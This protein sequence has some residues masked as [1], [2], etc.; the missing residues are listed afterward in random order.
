MKND[1]ILLQKSFEEFQK[2]VEKALKSCEEIKKGNWLPISESSLKQTS[3]VESCIVANEVHEHE[4]V[5]YWILHWAVDRLRRNKEQDFSDPDWRNYASLYFPYFMGETFD[6]L[7]RRIAYEEIY[8]TRKIALAMVAKLLHEELQTPLQQKSRKEYVVKQRYQKRSSAEKQIIALLSVFD[9]PLPKYEFQRCLQEL[10]GADSQTDL[11][12]LLNDGWI[13]TQAEVGRVEIASEL[14]LHLLFQIDRGELKQCH[15][16]VARY[17]SKHENYLEAA[18]HWYAAGD[19]NESINEIL[20]TEHFIKIVNDGKIAVFYEF[21]LRLGK[22]EVDPITSANLKI[23]MGR[24]AMIV[25]DNQVAVTILREALKCE[26]LYVKALAYYYYAKCQEKIDSSQA[27]HSFQRGI[28]LLEG[29]HDTQQQA[30]AELLADLYIGKAYVCIL[31]IPNLQEAEHCLKQAEKLIVKTDAVRLRSLYSAQARLKH[32]QERQVLDERHKALTT[33]EE[34]GD[35]EAICKAAYNIAM[36]YRVKSD[37]P[38]ALLYL[39]RANYIA[40]TLGDSEKIGKCIQERGAIAFH[41]QQYKDAIENFMQACGILRQGTNKTWLAWA[42]YDLAEAYSYRAQQ[43]LSDFDFQQ[44][45][46]NHIRAELDQLN[47]ELEGLRNSGKDYFQ[48]ASDIARESHNELLRKELENL[49]DSFPLY[50]EE[51]YPRQIIALFYMKQ[52]GEIS[53]NVYC[54]LTAVS[55]KTFNR[56]IEE[57]LAKRLVIKQGSGRS[58]HYILAQNNAF[59]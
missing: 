54:S 7:G 33:A 44:V 49:F 14:R 53:N 21:L 27:I 34:S 2:D 18:W 10:V 24:S 59:T 13:L 26:D 20:H 41:Q 9:R 38:R 5:L 4:V 22:E 47:A 23:A 37:F 40:E 16:I 6:S 42:C 56:D 1:A 48:Q 15:R 29:D 52:H 55:T 8:S 31:Q 30:V 39:Q 50:D 3:L 32:A 11:S 46:K 28:D 43:L 57:L 19:V 25:G 58:T 17:E 45:I 51:I 12:N 36:A 35:Q